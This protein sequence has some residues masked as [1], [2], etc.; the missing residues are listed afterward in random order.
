MTKARKE[1]DINETAMV[2]AF[3]QYIPKVMDHSGKLLDK[4][5]IKAIHSPHGR[6]KEISDLLK[7][8]ETPKH[9]SSCDNLY[10]NNKMFH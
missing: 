9:P 1:P 5:N 7:A 8:I 6:Y 10:W 2:Q 4:H 3:V